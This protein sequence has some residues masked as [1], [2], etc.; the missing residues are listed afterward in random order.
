MTAAAACAAAATTAAAHIT[1]HLQRDAG[2]VVT[3]HAERYAVEE[4]AGIGAGAGRARGRD[5]RHRHRSFFFKNSI[6]FQTTKIV[7]SHFLPLQTKKVCIPSIVTKGYTPD[8][9]S[10]QIHPHSFPEISFP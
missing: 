8:I 3:G 2:P 9:T 4:F 7:T 5:I 10:N 1:G 6:T